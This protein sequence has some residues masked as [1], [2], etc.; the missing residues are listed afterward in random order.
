VPVAT[1]VASSGWANPAAGRLTSH[2]GTRVHPVLGTIGL[3]AGQDIAN[4]CGT[5]VYAAAAGTVVWSGGALA[6]RTGNQVVIA[7]GNGIVT[8]YGHLLSGSV[9]VRAGDSVSAGQPIARMGGDAEID[10]LGAGNSTGCHLHLEVNTHDG[11]V[12]VD[13]QVWFAQRGIALGQDA[14]GVVRGAVGAV[15]AAVWTEE[16][17]EPDA[18]ELSDPL[19][20][21][22]LLADIETHRVP[23]LRQLG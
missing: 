17:A 2:F 19:P 13:P 14:P 23:V 15:R 16:A 9:D 1:D 18:V 22:D 5:P 20:L 21:E 11:L 6:G 4:A 12:P 3:H 10:P 7:H 8:R